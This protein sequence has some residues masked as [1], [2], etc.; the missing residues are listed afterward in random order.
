MTQGPDAIVIGSGFDGGRVVA[1]RLAEAGY[2]CLSPGV[3][4]IADF[5]RRNREGPTCRI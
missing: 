4:S 3:A 5:V 2:R 1:S